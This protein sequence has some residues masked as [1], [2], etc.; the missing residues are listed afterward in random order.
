MAEVADIEKGGRRGVAKINCLVTSV[1]GPGS[2]SIGNATKNK[3]ERDLYNKSHNSLSL[4]L[5]SH[6]LT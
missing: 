3:Y 5:H 2:D 1:S 6:S 4:S